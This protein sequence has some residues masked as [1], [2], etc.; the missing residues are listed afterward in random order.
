MGEL[1]WPSESGIAAGGS[2]KRADHRANPRL[3]RRLLL[4]IELIVLYL[5]IPIALYHLVHGEKLPLFILL[6]PVLLAFVLFL[7]WDNTFL[8]RR[9]IIKG[10]GYKDLLSILAVFII[11][12]GMV[13]AFVQQEM[14]RQFLNFPLQRTE[15]WQRVMILYPLAS[16]L[17]QELVYRTYFFH[18]YGPLFN[19]IPWIMIVANGALFGFAH[20][21]FGNWVAV[22]G[23]A[24]LG[25]LLAY[26]YATTRSLWAVFIEHTLYG[27]LVFTVGLG[28]FFFTGHS[29]MPAWHR[30][31]EILDSAVKNLVF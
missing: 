3:L 18:R 14:P 16:V 7:L 2:L 13:A 30:F 24:V 21:L 28:G 22:V 23:T 29:N 4:L 12:G 11:A 5:C 10:F 15:T 9:E 20:V 25:M 27:W 31:Q 6:P 17:V 1:R 8:L 19:G 26:R